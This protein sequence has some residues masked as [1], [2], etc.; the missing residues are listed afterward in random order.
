MIIKTITF[1]FIVTV[2]LAIVFASFV[3]ARPSNSCTP[4]PECKGGGGGGDDGGGGGGSTDPSG[5]SEDCKDISEWTA[6]AKW[7]ASK[8]VCSAK[9]TD[10]VHHMTTTSNIDLSNKQQASLTYSYHIDNADSGEYM[11][12]S[13][14]DDG[15][16]N[17]I[18]VAQYFGSMS[19]QANINIGDHVDLTSQI[20]LRASCFVSANN[21]DCNWDNINIES[22]DIPVE[23]LQ[24]IINS[25][26]ATTYGL[27]DFP[28]TFDVGLS[29]YGDVE[30]SL[31]GGLNNTVMDGEDGE[32]GTMFT[33]VENSL[34]IGTYTFE[35]YASDTQ[36]NTNN[37][38]SVVFN[39]DNATSAVEFVDP[40]PLD[41]SVQSSSN[42]EV[43]L[44][45]SSGF[46]HYSFV[47]FDRDLYLWLR[48]DEVVG[49]TV[50]DSSSYLNHGII[51]GD[52]SQNPGGK[53]GYAFEFHKIDHG[54]Q[55]NRINLAGFQDKHQIFDTSFTVMA[56][57]KPDINEKMVIAGTKSITN[58]PGWHLRTSGGSHRLRMGVNTGYTNAT[59][60]YAE[61]SD[62][63]VPN[64]W[65][66]VVG[67]YDSSV[68]NIQLYL[69]GV[70]ID[71]TTEGV[72]P[73]GYGNNLELAISVPEDPQ[74]AWD[75]LID[76]VLIFNRVLDADEIK[77]LYDSSANQFYNDY[78][79]LSSGTHE[80]TGYS[81]NSIGNVD[82]TEVRNVTSN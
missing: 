5:F 67:I 36:G 43:K 17:F 41:G 9:N 6:T 10:A 24:V 59:A 28:L 1:T 32:F 23:G 79:G 20:K 60:A 35:V 11:Q 33:A 53:F 22:V 19:G 82:Q 42:I 72:S 69:D 52:A 2:A 48:M 27:S 56:W 50:I 15:G 40:T 4:W 12:V 78:T 26:Q 21:E 70:L 62:P 54:E 55:I 71:I 38:E 34:P 81:V 14:S 73:F 64:E 49:N 25:P 8:G 61:T 63:I 80:F 18:D 7:S 75:G 65:V 30:Y 46:D 37:S 58:L 66:H 39:V 29:S 77:A 51:E 57:A 47:D 74:K 31:D 13:I 76:E 44:S 3:S 68:P 16:A 45:T